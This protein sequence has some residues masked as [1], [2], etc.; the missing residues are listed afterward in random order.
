M[1]PGS[2]TIN[3]GQSFIVTR[4]SK[5]IDEHEHLRLEGELLVMAATRRWLARVKCHSSA[6]LLYT[7][8]QQLSFAL[9]PGRS[10]D[11]LGVVQDLAS[12]KWAY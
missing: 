7:Q 2:E 12:R 10:L 9:T 8:Y 11:A 5:I 3:F 6:A 4:P 1:P